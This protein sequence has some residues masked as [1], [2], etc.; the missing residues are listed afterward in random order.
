MFK[1]KIITLLAAVLLLVP[2]LLVP[3]SAATYN[4]VSYRDI[5]SE[6]YSSN[7][8]NFY[9]FSA[10]ND[11]YHVYT[12]IQSTGKVV[13]TI[14]GAP[15]LADY[16]YKGINKSITFYNFSNGTWLR[17]DD[18]PNYTQMSIYIRY[19][20][21][22][23]INETGYTHPIAQIGITYYDSNQRSIGTQQYHFNRDWDNITGELQCD[24]IMD[25]PSNAKFC[26]LYVIWSHIKST[27]AD[28]DPIMWD[29][30]QWT[31]KIGVPEQ[32]VED[33]EE[34]DRHN[35]IVDQNNQMINQ[36]QTIIDQNGTM[37]DQND[38]MIDQM[39]SLPGDIGDEF[40]SV[41]Q[42]EDDKAQQ[43]GEGA[44]GDLMEIIPDK[45]QGFM[46]AIGGLVAALSYDGTNAKLPVPAIVLPAIPGVM[47]E[48]KLTDKLEVD[49]GYWV[50]QIPS[51]VIEV[52]QIICTIAL[53][54]YCFKE[55]YSTIAYAMTLK[56]GGAE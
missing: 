35:Q 18:I 9:T 32:A 3:V 27:V 56:G 29:I 49:F 52:V 44:A 51:N 23:L 42:K 34:Q 12:K 39:E 47:D 2:V 26:R 6:M 17:V 45:S 20:A 37:I 46:D 19:A 15:A 14:D 24:M 48:L 7:G 8:Y 5:Y 1:K 55:L 54:V 33:A 40:E 30:L 21:Y 13:E 43:S 10:P 22:S 38:Q 25:I 31:M 28:D 50:Q 16:Y 36:N 11:S 53:I 4:V 41:I